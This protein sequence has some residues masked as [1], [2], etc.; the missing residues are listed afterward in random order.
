[1]PPAPPWATICFGIHEEAVIAQFGDMLQ[2]YHSFINN[3]LGIW[4]VDTDPAKDHRKWTAFRSLMQYYYDLEWIFKERSKTVNSMDM[5]ISIHKDRIV[6]SL[7]D[8]VMNLYLYILPHS[9][10]PPGVLTGLVSGNIFC[11]HSLCSDKDDINRSM[12][13]FYEKLLVRSY[14]CDWLILVFT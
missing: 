6:T 5:T 14:Q 13:E 9:A 3:F 8:K 7:Y 1:M 10:H 4:L 2:L 11:V 12:K